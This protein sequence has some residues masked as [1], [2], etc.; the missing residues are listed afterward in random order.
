[1][2]LKRLSYHAI[3]KW[4]NKRNKIIEI[5]KRLRR[6][7]GKLFMEYARILSPNT[8]RNERS[9]CAQNRTA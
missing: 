3:M 2:Y 5:R 4:L 1:L 9:G 7:G 8:K 6:P